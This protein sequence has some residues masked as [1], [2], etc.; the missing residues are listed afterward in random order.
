MPDEETFIIDAS[1]GNMLLGG[2]LL[3]NKSSQYLI[4]TAFCR[5]INLRNITAQF[6]H[7]LCN[8]LSFNYVNVTV[9]HEGKGRGTN[10]A[11]NC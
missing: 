7:L 9:T 8:G 11:L 10:K 5:E 6:I 4:D 1:T 2:E 3:Q